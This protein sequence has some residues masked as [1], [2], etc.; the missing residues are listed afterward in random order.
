MTTWHWLAMAGIFGV[1]VGWL[2]ASVRMAR[3]H[4]QASALGARGAELEVQMAK[5][6]A[7][8]AAERGNNNGLGASLATV[9]AENTHLVQRLAEDGKRLVEIQERMKLEFENL[10]GRLLEEKSAKFLEQNQLHLGTLLNPLRE[11][12]GEF[13]ERMEIIHTEEEKSAAALGFQLKSL[14]ELNRQMAEEAGNL[15]SALKGQSKTQGSWG[16]LVLERILEKCGL[17][18]GVEYETQTSYQ[19]DDGARRMPDV[20]IH[21]P[22]GKN[23][24]IDA[25]VSLTAYEKAVNAASD[26]LRASAL[27]E[28]VLSVRRHVEELA[29]KDYPGLKSLLSPDFVLMFVPVEPALHLA[30]Q[31]DPSLYGD[32][33]EK[34]VVL[35]SSSTLLVAL[36]AVESV[37][38]HHKQTVNAQ[39]IA[40]QAGNLHDA[41]V[42]FTQ[43]LEEIGSRLDQ[44]K[45][46]YDSALSRLATGRGNLVR[47][48]LE[49]QKLGARSDK[50][51]PS[52]IAGLSE[53]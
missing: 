18:K 7:A 19:D 37:W 38:R 3:L 20:V 4:A 36:R 40:R 45:V 46:A 17:T 35:V 33:F 44:A 32:A 42:N 41:F 30:L 2:L 39:E 1:L 16:E 9:T 49:L 26:G 22:E 11:R 21:L 5:L 50:Q 6:D 15:T 23:L 24:I 8:L 52:G 43:S 12:L 14:H 34:N 47:R 48:T 25:K 51:L 13:R 53:E 27:R 31:E 28:H 10:A 29:K